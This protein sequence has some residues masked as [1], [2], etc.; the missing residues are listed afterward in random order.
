MGR[1]RE[2]D[3]DDAVRLAMEVFW[4][5]GYHN[6][7]LPDLLDGMGIARGSLYKTFKGKRSLF[8]LALDRYDQQ[9][10]DAAVSV[11]TDAETD[12]GSIRI[13]RLFEGAVNTARQGNRKGCLLCLTAAGPASEDPSIGT[14]VYRM[15]N[16]LRDAF[17]QALLSSTRM[18][19]L[20]D[21][22]LSRLACNLT[23]QYAGLQI[24]VSSHCP[25]EFLEASAMSIGMEICPES[26]DYTGDA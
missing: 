13:R 17:H 5:R 6:A 16:R 26:N 14:K 4:K 8:L 3:A 25:I 7:S 23:T 24:L 18:Q 2:F 22:S 1:P 12:E 10:V 19:H 21:Q 20:D 15:L 11:L 9:V